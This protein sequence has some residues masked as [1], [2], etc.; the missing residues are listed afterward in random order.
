[1]QDEW[2]TTKIVDH[3]CD[4]PET[5]A[6]VA[7]RLWADLVGAPLP[8]D[9]SAELGRWWQERDLAIT[10]LVE[11]ILLDPATPDSRLNRP[12]SGLE[13]YTAFRT[14]T[15]VPAEDPWALH[16][17]GQMPYQPPDVGGWIDGAR[18][19]SPGSLLARA[20]MAFELDLSQVERGRSGTTDDILDRCGLFEVSQ[21]TLDA[22]AEVRATDDLPAEAAHHTRWRLA[23]SSPELNL[24]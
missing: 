15:G 9:R 5:A 14:A 17:L 11:R 21:A 13:W 16:A 2:D 7:A 19:L 4:Q 24:A 23:L 18:W 8:A 1:V 10:D 22:L 12:R 3:L 6:R 20:S